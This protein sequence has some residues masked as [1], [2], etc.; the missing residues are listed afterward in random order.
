MNNVD[1][2]IRIDLLARWLKMN[3]YGYCDGINYQTCRAH[4]HDCPY[5]QSGVHCSD[6]EAAKSYYTE[7]LRFQKM[8]PRKARRIAISF[9]KALPSIL[10]SLD[11][12]LEKRCKT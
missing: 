6:G 11:R 10:R 7:L 2:V 4:E 5:C 1:G 3:P 12:E 8:K 9:A